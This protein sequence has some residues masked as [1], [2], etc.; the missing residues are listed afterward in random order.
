MKKFV[1]L[2]LATLLACLAASGLASAQTPQVEVVEETSEYRL[3]RHAGGE[4]EVPAEPQRIVSLFNHLTEGLLALDIQPV[5]A[6]TLEGNFVGYLL[7]MLADTEPVGTIPEPSLEAILALEP[8]LILGGPL[9]TDIYDQLSRIA[10]TIL[11]PD[12][13]FNARQTL[14]DLGVVL[15]MEDAAS[16]RIARFDERLAEAREQLQRVAPDAIAAFIR[17]EP[18]AFRISGMSSSAGKILHEELGF[19]VDPLVAGNPSGHEYLS[20]E[21]LPEL[22]ADYVFLMVDDEERAEEFKTSPLTQN[23][24][25]VSQGRVFRVDRSLWLLGHSGV[26]GA[27]M[28]VDDVLEFLG[29]SE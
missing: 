24:P 21:V 28:I 22:Q 7:P 27:E 1:T 2:K 6:V 20:L 16:A 13:I 9:H 12:E 14:V 25:A 5:G 15:G 4:T 8:D 17:A 26:I 11:V 3:I 29:E 23:I 19:A 18:Q 10:P